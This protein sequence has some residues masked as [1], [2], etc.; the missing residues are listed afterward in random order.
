MLIS[1]WIEYWSNY[2]IRFEISNIR[3]A[4]IIGLP[5]LLHPASVLVW[6]GDKFIVNITAIVTLVPTELIQHQSVPACQYLT[7]AML[8][9]TPISA[10]HRWQKLQHYKQ[11]R[12][13]CVI[14]HRRRDLEMPVGQISPLSLSRPSLLPLTPPSA[15][16]P[17]MSFPLPPSP[18]PAPLINPANRSGRAL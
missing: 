17:L 4:L 7:A 15:V 13:I 12:R 1:N 5:I 3:T 10:R 18:V 9:Q 16:H 11:K 8:L 2:S 14:S 6:S